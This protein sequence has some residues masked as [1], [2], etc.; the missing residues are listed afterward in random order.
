MTTP[1][2]LSRLC[3][4]SPD[5]RPLSLTEFLLSL[6][7]RRKRHAPPPYDPNWEDDAPMTG[8]S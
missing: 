3:A 7:G 2:L 6:A 1:R 4:H 5:F 8:L